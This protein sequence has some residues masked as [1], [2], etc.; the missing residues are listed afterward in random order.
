MILD[1]LKNL[2]QKSRKRDIPVLGKEKGEWLLSVIEEYKPKRILE[3]GTA[4][5]YS[6]IILG[7]LGAELI[8]IDINEKITNIAKDNFKQ[9]GTDAYIVIGNGVNIV[10]DLVAKKQKFDLIFIDFEKKR[11][12]DVLENCIKLTTGIIIADNITMEGCNDFKKAV[13]NHPKLKTKIINI[14]DGLSFSRVIE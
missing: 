2:E 1:Q 5:G 4:N 10:Q 7:S 3:L 11:Y 14:K 6:G 12:I 8:T 13:E 9:F